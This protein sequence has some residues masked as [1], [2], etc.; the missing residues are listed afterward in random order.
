[1]SGNYYFFVPV[2]IVEKTL[3]KINCSYGKVSYALKN[4]IDRAHYNI[5]SD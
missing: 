1:M 3:R 2:K 5:V 4:K